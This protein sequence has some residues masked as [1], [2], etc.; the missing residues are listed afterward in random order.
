MKIIIIIPTSNSF[1]GKDLYATLA[2]L[3]SEFWPIDI[4][5]GDTKVVALKSPKKTEPFQ[6]RRLFN[7]RLFQ[8]KKLLLTGNFRR[9]R[10]YKNIVN[11]T[12]T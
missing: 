5:Y 7:L 6:I 2:F 3:F 9:K 4:F 1:G 10:V 8:I 12:L 11:Q